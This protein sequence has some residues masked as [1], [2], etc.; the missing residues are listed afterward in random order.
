LRS[1]TSTSVGG[2]STVATACCCGTA[3]GFF[4]MRQPRFAR[5]GHDPAD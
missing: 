1:R 5:H 2:L 4:V 3:G